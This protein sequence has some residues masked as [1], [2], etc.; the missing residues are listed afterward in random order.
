MYEI[1]ISVIIPTYN[2]EKNI[3]KLLYSLLNQSHKP[4]EI[5]ISDGGSTDKTV[6]IINNIK[7]KN[8]LIKLCGRKG[9]C[10]GAG[11]NSAIEFSK[12]KIIALIDSGT[13]ARKN[14]LENLYKSSINLR[15]KI[16]FGSIQSLY[17]DYV[18]RNIANF[19]YGKDNKSETLNFSVSSLLL[20]KSIWEKVG[21][22]P[23]S[24]KGNYVV[25]DLRFIERIKKNNIEYNICEKAI[26]Y[27][28]LP[29]TYLSIFNRY[30]EYSIG[31]FEN[32]YSKIWHYK[33]FRNYLF[34]LL[35][36]FLTIILLNYKYLLIILTCLI[37]F[38]SHTYIRNKEKYKNSFFKK[39]FDYFVTSFILILIDATAFLG[40]FKHFKNNYFLK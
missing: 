17:D 8:D 32:N 40:A 39:L 7:K 31:A 5:I 2:E 28:K 27:W 3:S 37:F 23:E 4:D 21:K 34:L 33:V 22:F 13:V 26:V 24:K 9:K 36:I 1:K 6:D 12:N 16:V 19:I 15:N 14:W 25:E 35:I 20:E 30:K 11:R 38:R 29:N 10:R 18:S